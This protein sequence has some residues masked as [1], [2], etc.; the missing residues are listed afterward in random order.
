M[1]EQKKQNP[2]PSTRKPLG[3]VQSGTSHT[4]RSAG[5][6]SVRKPAARK[7]TSSSGQFPD[8]V[9]KILTTAAA[10]LKAT[11]SMLRRLFSAFYHLFDVFRTNEVTTVLVNAILGGA[12]L[13][14]L[15]CILMAFKPDF[16][17]M[18]A[19]SA[20]ASGDTTLAVRLVKELERGNYPQK[21]LDDT[22]VEV[23]RGF[24]R[25]GRFDEALTMLPAISDETV[26]TELDRSCSYARAA[27]DYENG[28]YSEAAQRFYQLESYA[29]SA[30]RYADCR[31][32]LAIEAYMAG[33]ESSARSLLLDV[34]DV[35]ERVTVAAEKACGSKEA[36]EQ[37]LSSDFFSTETL[38]RLEET[39]TVLKEARSD[40]PE[41]RIATGKNHTV[42]LM[43][44]GTVLAVGDNGMGQCNV[45]GW[46]GIIQIAAGSRHTVALRSDGTCVAT[47]DNSSGQCDVGGW[48]DI[49]AIAAANF[50]TIGLK[51]DGT[52]VA[53]GAHADKAA[54]WRDATFIS[55]G[56]YSFGCIY[57]SGTMMSS[58]SGAQMDMGVM[59][60]DLSVCS[61]VS[62]GI[63]YDGTMVSS[64]DGAPEWTGMVTA[65][66]CE[67]GIL[68]IDV[69]GQVRSFF[70]RKGS[71]TD[72][73][74]PGTAVEIQS[75]GTHHVV[76][77][78][79]GRVY[80]FGSNEYGQCNISD[81]LL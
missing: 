18:R 75:S 73:S 71:E 34:T 76:L 31:C 11:G 12:A 24:I 50:D 2:P 25:S 42:G 28:R 19:R 29:D 66:A 74:V 59:L 45:S 80:A 62:V 44:N 48:N 46:T 58:H 13:V 64:F 68:G 54:G 23:I 14:I 70:Y 15:L 55:A 72:I 36:A 22:R 35:V 43:S 47:G 3:P 81:W 63:L 53:T 38:A 16:D 4:R 1:S 78:D 7:G 30:S 56:G 17:S 26:R 41:G 20:A 79:D 60:Y 77:T 67:T 40:M 52:V 57:G 10:L 61:Q 9:K 5:A 37:I 69:D 32:A 33:D 65:T 27:S 8:I 21:K 6:S 39:M 49:V 51:S